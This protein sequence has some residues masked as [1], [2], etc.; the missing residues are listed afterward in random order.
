MGLMQW[1]IHYEQSWSTGTLAKKI[2]ELKKQ[3]SLT[4]KV[5]PWLPRFPT[6]QKWS[7][8]DRSEQRKDVNLYPMYDH[9][10]Q[11]S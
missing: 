8:S 1:L 11:P 4:D 7:A 6:A 10:Q 2:D 9:V 5:A 3:V